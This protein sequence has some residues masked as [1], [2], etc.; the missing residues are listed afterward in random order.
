MTG[1]KSEKIKI[2]FGRRQFAVDV[3]WSERKRLSITVYPDLKIVAKTPAGYELE[4]VQ[5]RLVKRASWIARQLDFFEQ[6]QSFP[7]ERKFVSGE[8]HYYLGRQYRLRTRRGDTPRVRL[9]GRFF[10]MQLPDPNKREKAKALMLDWY[11]EHARDLLTRRLAYYLQAFVRMGVTE[12][13]V[14]YRRIKKR[15]G[16]CSGNGN[17]MLNTELVKAP[18]HCIDYVIIHELCHLIC[19][20]HDR[21]FYQ[22]LGRILPDWEKRKQRLEKV[23]I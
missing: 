20:Q 8:T 11:S 4:V 3:M 16:S 2:S 10:E 23:I 6:F 5:Q 17:I 1:V 12:P 22:L 18:I 7:M 13:Q 19:P 21:K 9:L 15:W 14:R